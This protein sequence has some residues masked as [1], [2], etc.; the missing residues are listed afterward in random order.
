MF[1]KKILLLKCIDRPVGIDKSMSGI[2]RIERENGIAEL[3]LSLINLPVYSGGEFFT[4]IIDGDKKTFFFPLGVRPTSVVKTFENCPNLNGVAVCVFAVK[5]DLPYCLALATTDEC[6]HTVTDLK[7]A[8]AEKC[9]LLKQKK[10]AQKTPDCTDYPDPS[11]IKPPY[12]PAPSPDPEKTPPDEFDKP[13]YD[14]EA[15]ATTDYYALDKSIEHKLKTLENIYD[16]NVSPENE[17]P[18]DGRQKETTK[19]RSCANCFQDETD[20]SFGKKDCAEPYYL[21][22]KRELDELFVNFPHETTLEKNFYGSKFVK[23]NYSENKFY[24]VGIIPQDDKKYLCYGVPA[25]FSPTP[26]KEL[27]GYCSFI[28]LSIFDMKGKGYWMMF[29]DGVTGACVHLDG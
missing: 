20:A 2:A 18:F 21:T 25:N 27:K 6:T 16:R 29:Q 10:N 22:V 14:D 5:D 28:P 12:P 8:V 24:V 9:L 7:K 15:V 23:V 1:E 26:P 19:E 4:L 13:S 3:Y 17:L 11:P